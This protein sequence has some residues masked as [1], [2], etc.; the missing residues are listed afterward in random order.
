[1]ALKLGAT[2]IG[3]LYLGGTAISAAY[4]GVGQIFGGA[5]SFDPSTLFASGEV[6]AWY[7]PSDLSTMWSDVAA[8]VQ[9][10]PVL[11]GVTPTA[12]NVVAQIDDKSGNVNHATQANFSSRPVLRVTTGGLYYLELD[13]VDDSLVTSTI[14]PGADK[15]QI[16]AGLFKSS[17]ATASIALE[18]SANVSGNAGSF[19]L[20]APESTSI[21]YSSAGRGNVGLTIAIVATI[22]ASGAAPDTAVITATHDIAGDLSTIRR[23]GV[24]GNDATGDKGSG[25]F[26]NYPLY[27]GARAGSSIRFNGRIYSLIT[28]FGPSLDLST[29]QSAEGYVA[30]KTG[31]TL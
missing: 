28:R 27:I 2:T 15:A 24:G 22:T 4:L 25:N 10:V 17:D 29:I 6:G 21:R 18:L 19:Y 31:V 12:A 30:G 9:T 13:G 20:T 3:A 14:T 7:D 5:V 16:F 26:G 8:T 1:M 23:N 11:E